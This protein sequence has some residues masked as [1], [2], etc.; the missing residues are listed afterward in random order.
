VRCRGATTTKLHPPLL[1]ALGVDHK[2]TFGLWT[3]PLFRVLA[4]GKRVRG[5]LLDPSRWTKV[6]RAERAIPGECRVAMTTVLG[7]LTADT[8]DA[9]VR[10]PE[11]PDL[12]RGY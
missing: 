3:R 1:R 6:R 9:A 2:L 7:A 11:L 8:L 10:V 5:S 4:A 12:V